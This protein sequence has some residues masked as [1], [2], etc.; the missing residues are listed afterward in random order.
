MCTYSMGCSHN[1]QGG[2]FGADH[3]STADPLPIVWA[4]MPYPYQSSYSLDPHV[5]PKDVITRNLSHEHIEMITNPI[6]TPL[7]IQNGDGT[8]WMTPSPEQAEISDL[9]NGYA[10]ELDVF[11]YQMINGHRY[12]VAKQWSNR[13]GVCSGSS[14]LAYPRV[15]LIYPRSAKAGQWV[16][17]DAGGSQNPDLST[18]LRFEWRSGGYS[19]DWWRVGKHVLGH[20]KTIQIQMPRRGRIL[21]DLR[22]IGTN[23]RTSYRTIRI[24][25]S[26]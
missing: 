9:C 14:T 2:E 23:Q 21:L 12:S 18:P 26:G 1:D 3:E 17:I 4:M 8:G 13:R 11:P 16:T 24:P 5:D 20:S 19:A 7:P 6:A 22:V 25:V 15:H 10:D